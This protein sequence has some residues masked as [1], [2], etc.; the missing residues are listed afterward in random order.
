VLASHV[1]DFH[2]NVSQVV[3]IIVC[4]VNKSF[5]SIYF[6]SLHTSV[7][8]MEN[9]LLTPDGSILDRRIP[10]L[11]NRHRRHF[12]LALGS[13]NIRSNFPATNAWKPL[14]HGELWRVFNLLEINRGLPG[15]VR[16]RIPL[17]PVS[18]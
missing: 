9:T 11:A 5:S 17:Q 8:T 16:P 6:T 3:S 14:D 10:V 2:M 15:P 18:A 12:R 4:N 13:P 1:S 7:G